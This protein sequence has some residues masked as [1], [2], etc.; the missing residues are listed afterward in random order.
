[1][2]TDDFDTRSS[3]T[4]LRGFHCPLVS[5]SRSIRLF[6]VLSSRP[7]DRWPSNEPAGVVGTFRRVQITTGKKKEKEEEEKRH[8]IK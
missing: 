4:Q 3:S 2:M 1:M 5:S 7:I 6:G 8:K